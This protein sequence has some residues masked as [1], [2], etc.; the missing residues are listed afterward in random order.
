MP[1]RC[2]PTR[3]ASCSALAPRLRGVGLADPD[4]LARALGDDP[5]YGRPLGF[6]DGVIGVALLTSRGPVPLVARIAADLSD[7][8]RLA[9]PSPLVAFGAALFAAWGAAALA[10]TMAS[11]RT[12]GRRAPAGN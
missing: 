3:P 11:G 4:G 2:L 7:A 5:A 6:R 8:A 10:A 12:A 9:R 1:R